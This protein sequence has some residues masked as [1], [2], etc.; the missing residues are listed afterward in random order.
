MHRPL[1]ILYI[2]GNIY[3]TL[4]FDAPQEGSGGEHSRDRKT[5]RSN[6][7]GGWSLVTRLSRD[8]PMRFVHFAIMFLSLLVVDSFFFLSNKN[9]NPWHA[10]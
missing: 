4:L 7:L 1:A 3:L 9:S 5:R 6:A 2:G 10:L 8:T